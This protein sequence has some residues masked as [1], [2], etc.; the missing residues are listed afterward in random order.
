[1]TGFFNY[2]ETTVQT[3]PAA[4]VA[5]CGAC[6]L[7]KHCNSP[8]ME[9]HG[10]GR[11]K[12][13]LVGETP[14]KQADQLNKTV[15]D[16]GGRLLKR[17]LSQLGINIDVDCWH[18]YAVICKTRKGK[19]P[20]KEE[21]G[22]CRPNLWRTIRKL[23]PHG[24]ITFGNAP[25]LSIL[26]HRW[27]GDR[28]GVMGVSRWR[29]FTIPDRDL[30]AWFC[31]TYDP[32]YVLRS[33][34]ERGY[35][36]PIVEVLF[37]Q[38]LN[39]AIK[40]ILNGPPVI[41]ED[42]QGLIQ[43]PQKQKDIKHFI[44]TCTLQEEFVVF[45]WETTGLRPYAPGQQIV[46]ASFT[47]PNLETCAFTFAKQDQWIQELRRL[48][49]TKTVGKGAHNISFENIWSRTKVGTVNNWA[50]DSILAAHMIDNRPKITS[51]K[52]Q[53]Y[54]N[55]GVVDYDSH[56]KQWIESP[57]QAA[58]K[59]GANAFNKLRELVSTPP[60]RKELLTYNGLDSIYEMK[61]ALLQMKQLGIHRMS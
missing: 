47:K 38:D 2:G 23:K 1:M 30:K 37:Q 22:Y 35:K 48:L 14:R 41:P 7:H 57:P 4:K 11:K 42:E 13:L 56:M 44:E 6:N 61:L 8:K 59:S 54:I 50:W 15:C 60:G 9:V 43:M 24:I 25:I 26:Q 16:G 21:I 20:S 17:A 39:N 12:I 29:G 49:A 19:T 18:T 51:L 28:N 45:D 10:K 3:D 40:T 34:S 5:G 55:F 32:A 46:T 36:Q 27:K 58:K 53:A 31:P 33:K 52:V